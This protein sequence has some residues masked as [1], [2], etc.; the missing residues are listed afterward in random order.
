M[1]LWVVMAL[2]TAAA[3]LSILLPLGRAR[4]GQAA[5]QPEISIYKDQLDE[6]DRDLGR[7]LIAEREAGAARTEIARRLIKAGETATGSAMA[8]GGRGRKWAAGFALVGVP[9]LALGLYLW[10]LSLF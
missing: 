3:S 7:G 10:R 6:V 9:V 8:P 1:L 4:G 5:S 2:L